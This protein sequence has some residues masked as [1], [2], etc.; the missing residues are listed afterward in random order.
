MSVNIKVSV[1]MQMMLK[2]SKGTTVI[3]SL[4][5]VGTLT[6]ISRKEWRH[7]LQNS[8]K[9]SKMDDA[10]G[11]ETQEEREKKTTHLSFLE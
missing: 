6:L 9:T 1:F 7:R 3:I 5:E 4:K 11:N 8:S 2:S 10:K